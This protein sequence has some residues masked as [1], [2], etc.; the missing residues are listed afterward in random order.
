MPGFEGSTAPANVAPRPPRPKKD[1]AEAKAD[2]ES[3]ATRRSAR[4]RAASEAAAAAAV[5]SAGEYDSAAEGSE[6]EYSSSRESDISAFS[7]TPPQPAESRL[8]P[9]RRKA[10]LEETEEVERRGRERQ[11]RSRTQSPPRGR[12]RGYSE[13]KEEYGGQS[14]PESSQQSVATDAGERK[15]EAKKKIADRPKVVAPTSMSIL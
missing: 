3:R 10:P 9:S 14:E 6:G 15:A 1:W 11:V 12:K 7:L 13:E 4:I 8:T 5:S 2:E